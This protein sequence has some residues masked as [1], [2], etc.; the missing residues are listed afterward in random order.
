LSHS[1]TSKKGERF[2]SY[3]TIGEKE[4]GNTHFEER[5]ETGLERERF[6]FS[7]EKKEG[8]VS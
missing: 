3:A 6:I 4:K 5:R 7:G 8:V 1:V 2:P